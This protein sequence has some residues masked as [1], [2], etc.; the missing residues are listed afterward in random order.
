MWKVSPDTWMKI[1]IRF[2]ERFLITTQ[3]VGVFQCV[4]T[5]VSAQLRESVTLA[6]LASSRIH[7][8]M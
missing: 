2:S 6:R 1:R 3:C 7:L 4:L 8:S 5:I